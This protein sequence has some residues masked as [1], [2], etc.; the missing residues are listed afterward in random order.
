MD[1]IQIG[2]INRFLASYRPIL[3]LT[4]LFAP[5]CA[6][7]LWNETYRIGHLLAS[8]L[9]QRFQRSEIT[10]P[11]RVAGIIVLIGGFDRL[12]EAGRLARQYPHLKVVISGAK[13]MPGPLAELGGGINPSRVSLETHSHNTY[14]NALYSAELI[15]PQPGELWLLVT[16]ASH[17][18]RAIGSFRAAGFEVEPWPVY[19]LTSEDPQLFD[20]GVHEWFGLFVYRLLGRTSALFPSPRN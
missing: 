14:E 2:T 13:G 18:P 12:S 17:M 15:R 4:C 6:Y 7:I 9:E 3:I 8:P 20:V 5:L 1:P 19:D 10:A 16:G 11:E